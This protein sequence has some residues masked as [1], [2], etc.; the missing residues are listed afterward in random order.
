MTTPNL[1]QASPLFSG[2]Q[3]RFTTQQWTQVLALINSSETLRSQLTA[4][5]LDIGLGRATRIE[6]GSDAAAGK[7]ETVSGTSLM[8]IGATWYLTPERFVG[9]LAHEI[10]HYVNRLVDGASWARSVAT[11]DP[12][13]VQVACMGREGF[14]IANSIAIA[15]EI[16][17]AGGGTINIPG[18]RVGDDLVA[19][20]T[21]QRD[22]YLASG[23]TAAA[24]N[25]AVSLGLS[26]Y[27]GRNSV[28]LNPGDTYSQWCLREGTRAVGRV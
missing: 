25:A 19:M 20:A 1:T 16:N 15:R 27:N 21:N 28:S 9:V 12:T 24:A 18:Q 11:G 17:N 13:I 2:I 23:A 5:N 22:A 4:Y 26:G 3:R 10:G 8:T 6:L 14:A 7:F